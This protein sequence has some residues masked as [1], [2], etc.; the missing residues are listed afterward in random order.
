M[1]KIPIWFYVIAG[2]ALL[3]N[4]LGAVAVGMNF[5]ITPEAIASLPPEQQQM[6]ANTPKWSSYASLIAVIAGSL[7]ALA[8]LLKKAWALPLFIL[9]LIGLVIQNIGIF[10]IVD[11][12]A[13]LG[14]SVLIMQ[15]MVFLIAVGLILVS[16]SAIK[17]SWIS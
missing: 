3:W 7:G 15:G 6:Y 17:N 2:V 14:S 9:S 13:V 1:N 11:A 5:M 16:K 4:L 8:L 10:V 12:A